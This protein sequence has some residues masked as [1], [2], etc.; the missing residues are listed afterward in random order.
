MRGW[1]ERERGGRN[2]Q[3]HQLSTCNLFNFIEF[4]IVGC[5][6]QE[7]TIPTAVQLGR[8]RGILA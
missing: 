1:E 7:S 5:R 6:I 2:T 4:S 8:L 3:V